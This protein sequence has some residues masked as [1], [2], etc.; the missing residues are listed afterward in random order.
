MIRL[1]NW[2][3]LLFPKQ[4]NIFSSKISTNR[5]ADKEKKLLNLKSLKKFSELRKINSIL[6]KI[7]D[8]WQD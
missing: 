4:I 8:Y 5:K 7:E 1:F 2:A 3:R 6:D